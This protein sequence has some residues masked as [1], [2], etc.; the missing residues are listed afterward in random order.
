MIFKYFSLPFFRLTLEWWPDTWGRQEELPRDQT[1][2]Q[3]RQP[4]PDLSHLSPEQKQQYEAL[5]QRNAEIQR[6]YESLTATEQYKCNF[7][8]ILES[9]A[10]ANIPLIECSDPDAQQILDKIIA[11]RGEL[12]DIAQK[13]AD[14]IRGLEVSQANTLS[15]EELNRMKTIS[16]RE[17]LNA[18]REERLKFITKGNIDSKDVHENGTK[19][20]ECTFTYDGTY[21]H[22]LYARTTAGQVFPENVRIVESWWISYQRLG[23]DGEFFSESG[24]RLLIHEGTKIDISNFASPED[25][26]LLRNANREKLGEYAGTPNESLALTSLGKWYDPKFIVTVLGERLQNI[27]ENQKRAEIESLF[28]D[29]AHLRDKYNSYGLDT[30]A[31]DANGQ[32]SERF[33]GFILHS[34]APEKIPNIAQLYG[35]SPENLGRMNVL[36]WSWGGPIDMSKIQMDNIPPERVQ[37]IL[38]MKRFPPGS[39][40]CYVLFSAAC[41]SAGLSE[42]WA[43]NPEIYEILKKESNGR[44]GVLNYTIPKQETPESFREKANSRPPRD[45]FPGARSS[46][47]G[48]GQLLLSNVDKYYPDGRAGINNPLSEAVGMLRYIQDRYGSPKVAWEM[49]GKTGTYTNERTGQTQRKDFQEWY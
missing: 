22:E 7:A 20:L 8:D 32:P 47:S 38:Q 19:S 10:D 31:L 26:E 2:P 14:L 17:F 28:G 29:I 30:P 45:G 33:A 40:E 23:I 4:T 43:K 42:E 12:K 44:V 16:G 24:R 13:K 35:Y 6:E 46:A 36:A 11:L 34:F 49:Y 15:P 37:E 5:Q 48:L 9:K 1:N 21:N 39:Q 41:Q 25:L 18:P 27:P 3:E